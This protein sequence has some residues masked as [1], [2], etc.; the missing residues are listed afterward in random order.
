MIKLLWKNHS[1]KQKISVNKES[2]KK[3]IP[4]DTNKGLEGD[5]EFSSAPIRKFGEDNDI[6][7]DTSVSKE[8]HLSKGNK[9]GIID[10]LVTTLREWWK[11]WWNWFN[12][13]KTFTTL[14]ELI[15]N[16]LW[17]GHRQDIEQDVMKSV[18]D[19]DDNNSHNNN[20]TLGNIQRQW[21]PSIKTSKWQFTQSTSIYNSYI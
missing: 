9:L 19:T 2:S 6:R 1:L 12:I 5:N 14:R 3:I 15:E 4:G 13:W 7:S 18:I 16:K 11:E 21:W 20:R 17:Y 8:D 10:R